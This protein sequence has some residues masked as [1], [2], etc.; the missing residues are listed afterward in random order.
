[1]KKEM[2]ERSENS[3]IIPGKLI[4]AIYLKIKVN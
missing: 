4:I 3:E 2:M 1:M